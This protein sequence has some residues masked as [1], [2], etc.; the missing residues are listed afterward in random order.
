MEFILCIKIVYYCK[1]Y[2]VKRTHV[3]WFSMILHW[4]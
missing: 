3:S 2:C 1:P 4:S